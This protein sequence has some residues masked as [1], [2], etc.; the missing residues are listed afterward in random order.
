MNWQIIGG[1]NN[2]E[3]LK[4]K[5]SDLAKMF[6]THLQH[7][8]MLTNINA[9]CVRGYLTP[10]LMAAMQ[11]QLES[12]ILYISI[13]LRYTGHKLNMSEDAVEGIVQKMKKYLLDIYYPKNDAF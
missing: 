9:E 12:D 1:W 4:K 10:K 2:I 6:T 11:R 7:Y 13:F 3:S 5:S 8:P